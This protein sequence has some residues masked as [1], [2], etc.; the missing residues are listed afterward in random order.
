MWPLPCSMV[1]ANMRRTVGA[2]SCSGC[3]VLKT[4]HNRTTKDLIHIELRQNKVCIVQSFSS[5]VCWL[6]FLLDLATC[7]VLSPWKTPV[8]PTLEDLSEIS[9]GCVFCALYDRRCSALLGTLILFHELYL[10]HSCIVSHF[11]SPSH[12]PHL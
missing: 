3:I 6:C 12:P 2:G 10:Y 8:R 9:T 5:C 7:R 4:Q 11:T 1:P